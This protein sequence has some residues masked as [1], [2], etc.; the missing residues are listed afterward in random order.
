MFGE[1]LSTAPQDLTPASFDGRVSLLSDLPAI[2]AEDDSSYAWV[3]F[4]QSFADGGSRI[5]A[6]RQRGTEFDPPVAIDEP[7][8][9]PVAA[10]RDRP[11]RARR[12][13][14]DDGRPADRPAD[15]GVHRPR[16]VRDR[17]PLLC[18]ERVAADRGAGDRR[19]RRRPARRRRR[20]ARPAARGPGAHDRGREAGRVGGRAVAAGA[21]T[22]SRRSSASPSPRTARAARSS[23]GSRAGPRTAGSSPAT[24]TARRAS[25]PA[26]RRN[27]AARGR[28]RG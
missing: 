12:R 23:P 3:V 11:Q 6:R 15:G 7:G 27:A 25:S 10:P 21:W 8:G 24:S 13:R 9:E 2:D 4:R 16:P 18:P 26:T 17:Q 19:E 1:A 14:R 5:L 28:C 20:R 22:P